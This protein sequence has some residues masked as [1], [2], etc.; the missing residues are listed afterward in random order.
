MTRIDEMRHN[1]GMERAERR[2]RAYEDAM[3]IVHKPGQPESRPE[4]QPGSGVFVDYAEEDRMIEA[5]W[6]ERRKVDDEL[7]EWYLANR[8]PDAI[9]QCGRFKRVCADS[10]GCNR[11]T[12]HKPLV[13]VEHDP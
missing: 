11:P 4:S 1:E 12:K 2:Q 7:W 6:D 5:C 3:G 8:T 10:G 13:R 9:C